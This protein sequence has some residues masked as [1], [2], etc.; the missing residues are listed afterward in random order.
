M[1]R[2]CKKCIH[3]ISGSCDSWE[4]DMQTLEDYKSQIIDN[5]AERMKELIYKWIEKGVIAIGCIDEIAEQ[6]KE[7][8][9]DE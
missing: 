9:C 2:D 7:G 1:S 8:K 5:F 3:H 4:C 6:L